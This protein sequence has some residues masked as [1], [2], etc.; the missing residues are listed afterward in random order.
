MS[1]KLHITEKL[2]VSLQ[3]KMSWKGSGTKSDP[4]VINSSL[5]LSQRVKFKKLSKTL[6]IK[7]ITLG[8]IFL[9]KCRNITLDN[10]KIY[11]LKI[12]AS[13][14]IVVKNCSIVH[15]NLKYCRESTFQNNNLHSNYAVYRISEAGINKGD[16]TMKFL[17]R[18]YIVPFIILNIISI[19]A[20]IS[21]NFI[22]G[23]S[24][25]LASIIPLSPFIDI[26]I[27]K[28]FVKDFGPVIF[29]NNSAR[30]LEDL[31]TKYKDFI[32]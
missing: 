12:I 1:D 11:Y 22:M 20:F 14:N 21:L 16:H 3:E 32:I 27:K 2:L 30:T 19:L 23:L 24:S 5:G 9:M 7:D 13:H 17:Q 4:I 26:R 15:G 6:I 29:I 28:S 18:L 31:T 25:L 10:C 8:E